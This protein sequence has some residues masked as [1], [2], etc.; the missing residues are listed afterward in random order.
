MSG[1]FT[2]DSPLAGGI[3]LLTIEHITEVSMDNTIFNRSGRIIAVLNLLNIIH[4][5]WYFFGIAQ[6]PPDAWIA[7]NVCA[8][9]VFIYLAGYV[10]KKNYLMSAALPFLLFFGTGGLFVFGW[11]GPSIYAQ[12]SH[13]CMTLAA[14]WIITVIFIERKIILPAAGFCSGLLIFILILPLQQTYVKSHPE[15]LKKLGDS[16]FEKFINDRE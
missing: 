7:F 15:Y 3:T 12:A 5:I 14:L 1:K 13:I 16:T 8:P 11:S 10:L 6:F 4:S 9:S 2:L